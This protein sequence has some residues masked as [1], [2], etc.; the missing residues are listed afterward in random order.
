[1]IYII[2]KND[3]NDQEIAW[4]TSYY[5][6]KL[7]EANFN[8]NSQQN[9][10]VTSVRHNFDNSS[11]LTILLVFREVRKDKFVAKFI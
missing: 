3:T 9:K 10:I 8:T 2:I 1:M 5:T 6:D 7:N 4:Y 11:V